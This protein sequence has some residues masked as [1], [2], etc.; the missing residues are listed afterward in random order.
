MN[1]RPAG[2]LHAIRPHA[3]EH[4]PGR[5]AAPGPA[6]AV[7]TAPQSDDFETVLYH[8]THDL[9]AAVRPMSI[10]PGW[11]REELAGGSPAAAA[12]IEEHLRTLETHAA[13]LDRML[14][15]LRTYSRIGRLSDPP[16]PLDLN[17]ELD[18]VLAALA[19]PP[20]FEVTRDIES[21]APVAPRNEFRL[22]LHAVIGNA[23]KHH[24]RDRGRITVTASRSGGAVRLS[25][26]DDGP[27]IERRYRDAVFRM[28]ATLRPRDDV[29]GSGLGL[30]IARKAVGR[31]G[32]TIEIA[33]ALAPRGTCVVIV[34]PQPGSGGRA[35]S[36]A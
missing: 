34:L 10:V 8:I 9:R 22:V 7:S 19:L 21:A 27:G 16:G 5:H 18:A 36:A 23:W 6:A 12:R 25:V 29:E 1:E 24:D 13:R 30:S 35:A 4:G 2:S 3:P 31:L 20:G 32:G 17:A 26:I 33:E 15:D 11:V 14:I 28:M